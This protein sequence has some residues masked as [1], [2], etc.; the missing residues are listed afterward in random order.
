MSR[1]SD[2]PNAEPPPKGS[3]RPRDW[4]D[5]SIDDRMRLTKA[6]GDIIRIW[7]R[8]PRSAVSVQFARWLSEIDPAIDAA[9]DFHTK[10][11]KGGGA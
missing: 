6:L 5:D 9:R 1:P 8:M 3:P 2:T 4:L 11:S 10:N 7:D